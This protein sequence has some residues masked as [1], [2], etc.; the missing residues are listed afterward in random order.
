MSAQQL[1]SAGLPQCT[2]HV[3]HCK[4]LL[5]PLVLAPKRL[6]LLW[7]CPVDQSSNLTAGEPLW[8][9]A[10]APRSSH[11]QALDCGSGVELFRT[12]HCS[13]SGEERLR[14][15]GE[16]VGQLGHELQVQLGSMAQAAVIACVVLALVTLS[17]TGELE[18]IELQSSGCSLRGDQAIGRVRSL[19]SQWCHCEKSQW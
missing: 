9:L 18:C 3:V 5:Y 14:S 11:G 7:N 6:S 4:Q 17:A 2:S 16:G 19:V 10:R 1:L 8:V 15:A 12:Q 13:R